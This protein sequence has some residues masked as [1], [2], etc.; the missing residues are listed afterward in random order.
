MIRYCKKIKHNFPAQPLYLYF[1]LA[2]V[3]LSAWLNDFLCVRTVCLSST[4]LTP[5][6]V[7]AILSRNLGSARYAQ[8]GLRIPIRMDPHYFWKLNK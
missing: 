3:F 2:L 1:Y 7:V 6:Q 8:P 4:K 5:Q